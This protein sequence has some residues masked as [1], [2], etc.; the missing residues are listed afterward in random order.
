MLCQTSFTTHR[1]PRPRPSGGSRGTEALQPPC[2][3]CR[4]WKRTRQVP[5]AG[6]IADGR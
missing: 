4:G 2:T 3:P 1:R 5:E 6:E